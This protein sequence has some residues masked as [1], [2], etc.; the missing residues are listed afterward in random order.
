MDVQ[1]AFSQL[2]SISA[3]KDKS[4]AYSEL[5]QTILNLPQNQIPAA[6]LTY[7]SLI[8]NRDQPGIVVAR[9]VLSE[10]VAAL[11]KN[12]VEDRETRKKLI[13]DVLDTLQPRL[14]SYEEQVSHMLPSSN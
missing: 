3:Q 2:S 7:V 12:K 1:G 4:T 5:L 6:L 9:Q 10:L 11:E 8:V 14:V 13:E